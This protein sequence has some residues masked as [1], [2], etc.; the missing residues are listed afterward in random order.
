MFPQ[1]VIIIYIFIDY[2]NAH[3]YLSQ[4]AATYI[5]PEKTSYINTVD[6]NKIFPGVK[7]DD[8]PLANTNEL[9][10]KINDGSFPDLKTF[11]SK[12]INGCPKNNLNKAVSVNGLNSFK[13]QNDEEKKGFINTHDGPCE[14]WIDSKKIF[15]NTNC[16]KQYTEYPAEVP[17]DYSSCSGTC[18]FEFYWLAMHEYMWQMYKACATIKDAS[19]NATKPC[20]CKTSCSHNSIH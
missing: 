9:I 3:G 13:W 10:K 15:S 19:Q 11:F 5:G 16:A 17:I 4:P 2:I 1:S 7:W 20:G 12:Y 18:Q 6:G 14:V 8:T